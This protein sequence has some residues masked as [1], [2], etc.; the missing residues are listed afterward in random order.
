MSPERIAQVKANALARVARASHPERAAAVPY[1]GSRF[2]IEPGHSAAGAF[3]VV[4][5]R[6][7][8]IRGHFERLAEAN[9]LAARLDAEMAA[10][11]KRLSARAA[12]ASLALFTLS[13]S[14]LLRR[15]LP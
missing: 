8:T 12:F 2:R 6:R 4:H 5:K 9:A 3:R 13:A 14:S 7:G 1:D 15:M 10:P 11:P